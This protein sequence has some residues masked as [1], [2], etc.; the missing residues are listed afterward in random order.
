MDSTI[1]VTSKFSVKSVKVAGEASKRGY[2]LQTSRW[3]QLFKLS[4][5]SLVTEQ[6]HGEWPCS[7][8]SLKPPSTQ[9][10]VSIRLVAAGNITVHMVDST[11]LR[12]HCEFASF[13]ESFRG[14]PLDPERPNQELPE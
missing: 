11:G 1:I 3:R 10:I 8:E 5:L 14:S 4:Q 6:C 13:L 2:A 12:K 7:R 9:W